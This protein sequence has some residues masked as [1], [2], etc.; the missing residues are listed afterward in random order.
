MLTTVALKNLAT[1]T[2]NDR[3]RLE[4]VGTL[5]ILENG[6]QQDLRLTSAEHGMYRMHVFV[7][8]NV[9]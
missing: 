9:H 7:H 1:S 5:S 4:A 2:S 8:Y 3:V 6:V